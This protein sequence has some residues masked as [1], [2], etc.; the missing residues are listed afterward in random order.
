MYAQFIHKNTEER[1][2]KY[3]IFV[4]LMCWSWKENA[5]V[6]KFQI[7]NRAYVKKT[8]TLQ[9]NPENRQWTPISINISIRTQCMFSIKWICTCR[10]MVGNKV[11]FVDG[12]AFRDMTNLT[13]L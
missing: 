10:L 8:T 9:K 6:Y 5:C 1:Y 12:D 4:S 2:D 11:T 13:V 7:G 3:L